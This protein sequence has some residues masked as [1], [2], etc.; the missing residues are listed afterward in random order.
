MAVEQQTTD[1]YFAF[2][3]SSARQ[4]TLGKQ[5]L[6]IIVTDLNGN[7]I[8]FGKATARYFGKFISGLILGIGYIMAG[9]TEKKQ[10]L[11]DMMA[12]CLVVKK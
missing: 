2:M 8:Y 12:R 10:A 1:I 7:R 4:A 3:E 11:H 6:G 9:F 5:A